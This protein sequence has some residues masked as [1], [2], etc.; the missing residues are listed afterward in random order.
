MRKKSKKI[1]C[2]IQARLGS[3]RFPNKIFK[4]INGIRIIHLLY[5]RLN[6]SK[7]IK[8]IIVAIPTSAKDDRLS[9]Y[10][11]KNKIIFFRG[12]EKNVLKRYLQ[13]AKNYK[14]DIIIR[15]TSDCPIISSDIVDE[16]IR[17]YLRN[18]SKIL[19]NY[20]SKTYPVGISLSICDYK[21][22]ETANQKAKSN[23]DK[24]HVMPY[25]YKNMKNKILKTSYKEKVNF[26]RLT[27]DYPSDLI[28]IKN[29]FNYFYP[30][31]YFSWKK[32]LKLY[33]KKSYLFK[34]NLNIE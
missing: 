16:Q 24:E 19:T 32:V 10:L 21:S 18:K 13:T 27:L 20:L 11:S 3:S 7:L 28:T 29:V 25:I 23:Y 9:N 12:S 14:A 34:S 26:L 30:N 31:I 5:K 8:K 33:K 15:I 17:I 2:I 6:K 4:K 1:V 22:L